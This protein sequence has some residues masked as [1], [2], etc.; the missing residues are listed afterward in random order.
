GADRGGRGGAQGPVHSVRR[1]A[2]PVPAARGGIRGEPMNEQNGPPDPASAPGTPGHGPPHAEPLGKVAAPPD[3]ESTSE[4]F[5]FWVARGKL[6]ERT[7]I[8]TTSS[9]LGGRSV[10][11]VGLV[12]E[13][14]RQSRQHDMGEEVARYAA[15][16]AVRPL[17]ESAGFTYAKVIILRTEPVC[18][19]PPTE[20]S[21]VYLGGKR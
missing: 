5:Y 19:A 3:K 9:T 15:A 21:T 10:E 8:V 13:V 4:V 2:E 11:F 14:Y 18:H 1:A 20:E 6:V 16:A 12:E 17:F 7:Q